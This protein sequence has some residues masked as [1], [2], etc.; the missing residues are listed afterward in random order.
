MRWRMGR[1]CGSNT[2]T[3]CSAVIF[4]RAIGVWCSYDLGMESINNT[5]YTIT[6]L[7]LHS[8]KQPGVPAERHDRPE[9]DP[10]LV[11]QHRL[12]QDRR[13]EQR[14]S[15]DR[16][17]WRYLRVRSTPHSLFFFVF[18]LL[19]ST[20]FC[21]TTL[22]PYRNASVA[23]VSLTR[24]PRCVRPFSPLPCYPSWYLLF[25]RLLFSQYLGRFPLLV[26]YL[27]LTIILGAVHNV[28][29]HVLRNTRQSRAS[30]LLETNTVT[31]AF[32]TLFSFIYS[33]SH[34]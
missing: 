13:L 14:Q 1:L 28:Q 31:D 10:V 15:E 25:R 29:R 17:A 30:L 27:P 19:Y 22:A 7:H 4:D 26:Y 32:V 21:T 12:H 8:E 18:T 20:L 5:R 16:R 34:W 6:R 33:P 24:D 2:S 11:G 9:H 23:K 3:G